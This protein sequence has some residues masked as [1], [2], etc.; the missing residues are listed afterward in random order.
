M[1]FWLKTDRLEP[2]PKSLIIKTFIFG[3]LAAFLTLS[4]QALIYQTN[5]LETS[6]LIGIIIF[7]FVEEFLKY[8]AVYF[9]A[10]KSIDFN[11]RM[12]PVLYMITAALGFVAVEN[13]LYII[14]YVHNFEYLRSL[15]DGSYRFIGATLIHTVASATVGIFIAIVFFQKKIWRRIFAFLGLFFAT[16]IHTA[17]NYLVMS[18]NYELQKLAFYST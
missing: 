8:G 15:I 9:T 3:I 1:F 17:F 6:F 7:A 13:T 11:E 10:L 18:P 5:I 16:A 4:I 2:E 14:D 12:D